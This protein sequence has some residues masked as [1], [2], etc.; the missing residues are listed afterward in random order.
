MIRL[1]T[2]CSEYSACHIL[3]SS[4]SQVS[5][6]NDSLTLDEHESNARPNGDFESD[7]SDEKDEG[8]S[9]LLDQTYTGIDNSIDN[10]KT[11]NDGTHQNND[12]DGTGGRS[13]ST[14][15]GKS[16]NSSVNPTDD[17]ELDFD[18]LFSVID[19]KK[20]GNNSVMGSSKKGSGSNIDN[21]VIDEES[22]LDDF[23]DM[24]DK[25]ED[26]NN[27]LIDSGKKDNVNKGNGSNIDNSMVD[28]ELNPDY[29]FDMIDKKEYSNADN[30]IIDGILETDD[31][32]GNG[33]A[34]QGDHSNSSDGL[35]D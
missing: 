14:S 16:N 15:N 4:S 26:V 17:A 22:D 5:D 20:D 28:G 1:Q 31:F 32:L 8:G 24:V 23:F 10:L 13:H 34:G 19:K 29:Y 30:S 12:S 2:W 27:N 9:I 6:G 33:N 25:K 3:Y 21:S 7:H 11:K 18:E 35:N